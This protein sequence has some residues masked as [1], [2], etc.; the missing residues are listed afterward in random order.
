M[1]KKN[2]QRFRQTEIRMEHVMLELMKHYDFEKITVK[3]IC[4]KAQVNRSTFYA[5]FI[6][7]YD[8]LDKMELELSKELLAS[9][10]FEQDDQIFSETSFMKFLEHIKKHSYFYKINLQNRKSFPIEQGFDKVWNIIKHHCALAGINNEDE[11]MYYLISFQAGFTMIL[12]HWVDT[13]CVME[14]KKIASII[15]NC[16]PNIWLNNDSSIHHSS[17]L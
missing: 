9:Y 6:D 16:I 3:K 17:M 12:K 4:E 5:H 13:D 10:Q 1:N 14:N 7:L 2:N 8:M 11:I 15:R